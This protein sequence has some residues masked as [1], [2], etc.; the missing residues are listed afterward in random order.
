MAKLT[1][2]LAAFGLFITL[3]VIV[4]GCAWWD[5]H[6]KPLKPPGDQ[7]NCGAEIGDTGVVA[8]PA[9]LTKAT[10]STSC[11][12]DQHVGSPEIIPTANPRF[13]WWR[14]GNPITT[15]SF[16]LKDQSLQTV[17]GCSTG[18]V[19][20]DTTFKVCSVNLIANQFYYGVL[21]HTSNGITYTDM[22]A[23]KAQ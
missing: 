5:N 14:Y 15:W 13:C 21:T 4:N 11:S 12:P 2:N 1:R 16:L 3:G 7:C 19:S 20:S 8:V 22:H 23:Y 17:P 18:P 6:H 10:S 9:H